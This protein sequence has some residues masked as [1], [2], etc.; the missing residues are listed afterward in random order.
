MESFGILNYYGVPLHKVSK[1]KQLV[2]SGNHS[3]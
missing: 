3:M 2:F 1:I